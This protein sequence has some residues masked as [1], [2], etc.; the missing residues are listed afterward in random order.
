VA[1]LEPKL[2][3]RG[4]AM[5]AGVMDYSFVSVSSR[6]FETKLLDWEAV[7]VRYEAA[8]GQDKDDDL[9]I[10]VLLK[11]CPMELSTYLELTTS[12]YEDS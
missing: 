6:E 3:Q 10:A 7:M 5:L 2:R 12:T 4:L 8:S 11:S 9:K 1:D